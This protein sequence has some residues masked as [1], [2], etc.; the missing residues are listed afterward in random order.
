MT[1]TPTA[2][3]RPGRRTGRRTAAAALAAA[4]LVAPLGACSDG[5]GTTPGPAGSPDGAPNPG[6]RLSFG[7]GYDPAC[8]DPQQ[9]GGNDSLNI[10]RQLVDS[11]TDQDPDTGE[12][13]PWL[14]TSWE[15]SPDA[16]EFTFTLRDDATFADGTPVD[17]EAVQANLDGIAALGAQSTLGASYL[18]GY[19]E[20]VVEDPRTARVVFDRPSAQFLQ[21]TS[22]MTLG[23]ISTE[24]T[25]LSVEERCAGEFVGSGPFVLT[26]WTPAQ[27]ATVDRRDDYAWPSAN[28][29][30]EGP[31]HLDGIDFTVVPEASVRTG[32]IVSGQLDAFMNVLPADEA[33]L[34][35]AG[36]TVSARANP[37][38]SFALVPNLDRPV[39]GDD[40]VRAAI[41]AAIDRDLVV[42][43]VL[44]PSYRRATGPLTS[45][46]P[47]YTDLS[48]LLQV[49]VEGAARTL[50]QAGWTVGDDG[51]R[52]KD[53]TRLSATVIYITNFA[54]SEPALELVQQQLRA[55][56]IELVLQ[57]VQLAEYAQA[58]EDGD[59]DFSWNSLTRADGDVLRTVYGSPATLPLPDDD[60]LLDELAAQGAEPDRDARQELLD[61]IQRELLER[62]LSIPVLEFSTVVATAP[63]VHDVRFEA[64]SRLSFYDTWVDGE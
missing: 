47:A 21:A 63:H 28:A 23:L 55:I 53:G 46:N 42:D 26:G 32:S 40:A 7:L 29:D 35:G 17:A 20:T 16:T 56:G 27:S 41:S 62:H 57:E 14:A 4:L 58:R 18:S 48:D 60:P 25:A 54:G 38:I 45:S 31:A 50:D 34:A 8:L 59:A 19:A 51:I 9:A 39:A 49:D 22:T 64:S 37:G 24:S 52:A 6:G 1:P 2:V 44:T 10:G 3:R 13:V 30:H 43:T 12:I 5:A 33:Q 36:I 15:V 11:L 61:G